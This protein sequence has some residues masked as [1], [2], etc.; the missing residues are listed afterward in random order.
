MLAVD[1]FTKTL[2]LDALAD[3]PVHL[4]WT[5]RLRLSFNRGAAFGLAP[6]LTP[7]LAAAAIVLVALLAAMGRGLITRRLA[8]AIGLLLG[9]AMGNLADRVFRDH[10]GAVVDFI[11]LQWWPVFNVADTAITCGAV[12]MVIATS[13][14]RAAPR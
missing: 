3:G 13:T 1:Q 11:D 4:V 5:L 12:V 2:A 7:F 8:V 6:G 14:W 10:E 9:G